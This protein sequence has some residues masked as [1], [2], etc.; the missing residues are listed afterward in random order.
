MSFINSFLRQPD[1]IKGLISYFDL[2]NW[3]LTTFTENEREYIIETFQPLGST[4]DC[5]IKDEIT[6]ASQTKIDFLTHLSSWFKK[7]TDHTIG[8]RLIKKADDLITESSDILDVHFLYQAKIE[9]YYKFREDET[10]LEEAINACK[11]QI[12]ISKKAKAQFK[13]ENKR[14]PL[15]THKGFEQLAILEE[16][17]NNY[18]IAIDIS[19]KAQKEGWNGDWEGRIERCQKKISKINK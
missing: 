15:P 12:E 19:K 14:E 2:E 9:L 16:K 3:W 6:N 1:K 17:R 8:F 13:I 10:A 4:G 18:Q 5:L 11:K 7:N